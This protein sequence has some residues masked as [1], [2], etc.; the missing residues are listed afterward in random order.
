MEVQKIEFGKIVID[1]QEYSKDIIIKKG[2]IQKR[3]KKHSKRYRS[4]FGHTPLSIEENIPWDCKTL[5]IG[6][7]HYGS[8]PIMNEVI[9]KA[10]KLNVSLI[11]KPSPE[12]VKNLNEK[13]TN[14]VIHLTC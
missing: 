12:A 7:G 3:D 10:K 2:K 14:Y 6:N 9:K 13:E 11:I 1:N 8:L 5:V 4:E